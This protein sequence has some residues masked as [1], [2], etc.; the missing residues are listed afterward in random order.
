MKKLRSFLWLMILCVPVSLQA[1]Q[2]TAKK[3]SRPAISQLPPVQ[4]GVASFYDN[5]FEG[6]KTSNGDI[7]TQKKLTA[8]SNTLP[9]N[10][11]VKVTNLSNKRSVVLKITDRMHHRNKR[12]IDLSRSAASKLSYIGK[13]LTRVKVEYL[14]KNRPTD[15]LTSK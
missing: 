8:A 13:G 14:G 2:K 6:R 7:F 4:Y 11:W 1:Q 5:K 12:L 9:L 15:E 3:T 10:C